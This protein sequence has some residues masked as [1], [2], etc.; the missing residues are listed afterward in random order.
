M[1]SSAGP[2]PSPYPGPRPFSAA[3][4][5][6]FAGRAAESAAVAESWQRNRLTLLRGAAGVGKT[7]LLRAGVAARIEPER[8]T[9][10]EIGGVSRGPAFPAAALPEHN[11]FS[12][13]L[14][15]SW[16]PLEAPARL[17]GLT[18]GDFLRR[19][20]RPDRHG[21]TRPIL[22]AIDQAEGVFGRS[23]PAGEFR[24][25]L[26]AALHDRPG[27][28]LLLSLRDSG[29]DLRAAAGLLGDMPV[30]EVRLGPLG[31]DAALD[32]VRTPALGWGV[33]FEPGAAERLV[34]DLRTG[35]SV[36]P[37]LLQVAC[38]ALWAALPDGARSVP[39]EQVQ[40]YDTDRALTAFCAEMLAITAAEHDRSH[41]QL[42]TLLRSALG[43][44]VTG[45]G[46]PESVLRALEER[47]LL[48][49]RSGAGA[50]AYQ[51]QSPRLAEPV[52][53]L[54][55]RNPAESWE[56]PAERLRAA[57]EA[58]A[59]GDWDFAQRNAEAALNQ[60][61]R[62]PDA[63]LQ[64]EADSFLGDI[65]YERGRFKEA[66]GHY[67]SAADLFETLQ[68]TQAVGH[69]LVAL[70]RML[71]AQ[72]ELSK[73]VKELRA[74]A[75]R[76]PSDVTVQTELGQALWQAGQPQA[77]LAVLGGVLN[78]SGNAPEA[79]RTRGEILADL[80]DAESALRD[81]D[82]VHQIR[83]ATR[84]ARAL[85]LATLSRIDA[86]GRE[87][88]DVVADAADSGPVLLRAA[89]VHELSGDPDAATRLASR[90]VEATHPRLSPDQH[91]QALRLLS[92]R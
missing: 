61:H 44:A 14:L 69:L 53:Q 20:E 32:A 27:V 41:G 72:G 18:I 87:L 77:A 82:R 29:D 16:D 24:Q 68:D 15:T 31:R 83:P 59:E 34:D 71:L 86:A 91:D 1:C 60:R 25:E 79:L 78:I 37:V 6:R 46:V 90:A 62:R 12:F 75:A 3:E 36:E 43:G 64:A 28:H 52:A 8:F 92:E 74:A 39:A 55:P 7:S 38:G 2:H 70:G 50:P 73:A 85:A 9:V 26:A 4:S 89:R 80:G 54:D 88:D 40:P 33:S 51:L 65:A 45:A 48:R 56:D 5:G 49:S 35:G 57:R 47:H 63:R 21:R 67:R 81:L 17:V 76:M 13:A 11:P 30:Q 23:R 58:L 10:L 22:I 66:A 19:R 84:A 42:V